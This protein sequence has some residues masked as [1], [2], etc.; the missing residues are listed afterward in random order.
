MSN[1]DEDLA[2]RLKLFAFFPY[3]LAL[4]LGILAQTLMWSY[5][6]FAEPSSLIRFGGGVVVWLIAFT[7]VA[8]GDRAR[9]VLVNHAP[10]PWDKADPG[11]LDRLLTICLNHVR[12]F[13][14]VVAAV[15]FVVIWLPL[16]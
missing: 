12:V 4:G 6:D 3:V 1:S 8:L 16:L 10:A 2:A 13:L 5:T 14:L 11:R 7:A 9:Q 15:T